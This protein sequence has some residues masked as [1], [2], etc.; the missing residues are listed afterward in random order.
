MLLSGRP[1][2]FIC[3]QHVISPACPQTCETQLAA[4]I[5]AVRVAFHAS[6]FRSFWKGGT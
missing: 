6:K 1:D 4:E 3:I 2:E 5:F